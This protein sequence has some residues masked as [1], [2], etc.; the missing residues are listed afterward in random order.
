MA[1][2]P[3]SPILSATALRLLSEIVREAG[4]GYTLMSRS[5][6]KGPE[7]EKAVGE[8]LSRSLI[9]VKG[10]TSGDRLGE[11]YFYVPLGAQGR[12]DYLLGRLGSTG[13]AMW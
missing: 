12:A 5:G 8:L 3:A 7:F 10:D 1:T 11:S 13:P 2:S 9:L 4:D 6:L